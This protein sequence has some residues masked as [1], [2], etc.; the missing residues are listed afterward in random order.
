MLAVSSAETLVRI[1]TP[2]GLVVARARCEDGRVRS[3]AFR[4][5][6]S[7]VLALDEE[8]EVQGIGTVH[9]DLA[10]GGAFYAFV[11]A[12]E[13]GLSLA[14]DSYRALIEAGMAIKSAVTASRPVEHP[15]EGD[16][17]FL[18][19]TIFVGPAEGA[20]AHSR[21]VCVFA[22]GEVD[23]SPTGT[24]VSARAAI[25]HA[26]GELGL[27]E[28]IT[29]ESLIGTR[30]RVTALEETSFGPHDAVIPEVEGSAHITGEHRFV[31]D[32][33]DPLQKG[34]ILR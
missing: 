27:G 24:G 13:Y 6:P 4:N 12:E 19:G 17:S 20:G 11:R 31:I 29:V 32:P 10:F 23:R 7:F 34:F 14:P 8:V 21:N 22:E 1:D 9:Y 25:L 33:E 15:C 18:Y 26:R 5:V 3:V 16:L 2:A 30:F 28:P